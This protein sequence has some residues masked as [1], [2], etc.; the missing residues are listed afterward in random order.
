MPMYERML[1]K[2]EAPAAAE[3]TSYCGET[4]EL[5]T[6]LNEWLGGTCGTAQ[7]IVFPYGKQYGWGIAHRMGKKL[8]CNI[9]PE[10]NAFTVMMRLSNA[11]FASKYE[12]MQKYTREYI[13]HKYSC[14]DG[15]WIQYRV[16][17]QAHFDDI[18][19]LLSVKCG[20]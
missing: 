7:E 19:R 2:Q 14:G 18:Q 8:V 5:F 10:D 1:N 13:D 12:T 17:C 9:F 3:M 11:Q 6:S 4:A 15:G 20:I 16:T